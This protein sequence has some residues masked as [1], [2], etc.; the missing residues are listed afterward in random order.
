MVLL[1]DPRWGLADQGAMIL[2]MYEQEVL[3]S[4]ASASENF[5]VFIDIGAADGYYAVGLLRSG[6]VDRAICFEAN[7]EGR[8]TIARLAEKNG[9][10]DKMTILGPA[11]DSF[12]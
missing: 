5:R 9:V 7:P 3:E 1:G 8:A 10:S 2:G 12:C 11:T 6:R 4:L